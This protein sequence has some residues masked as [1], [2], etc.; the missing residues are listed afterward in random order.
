MLTRR[1]RPTLTSRRV[2]LSIEASA[3]G[4]KSHLHMQRLVQMPGGPGL[5]RCAHRH[6]RSAVHRKEA[7]RSLRINAELYMASLGRSLL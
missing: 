3:K 6:R 4:S 1:G 7:G 2:L 5:Q